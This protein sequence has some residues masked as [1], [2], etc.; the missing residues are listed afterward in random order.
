V[1]EMIESDAFALKKS[2]SIK[3]GTDKNCPKD[4]Y[5]ILSNSEAIVTQELIESVF[6]R[7]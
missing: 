3:I 2:G 7:N 5:M 6:Q 1:I 4:C